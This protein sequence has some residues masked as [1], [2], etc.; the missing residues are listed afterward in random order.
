MY[1]GILVVLLVLL[2]LGET[3]KLAGFVSTLGWGTGVL[4]VMLLAVSVLGI[5]I[6][7]R[8]GPVDISFLADHAKTVLSVGDVNSRT[9]HEADRSE[10]YG[11]VW[12]RVRSSPSNLIVGEGFGQALINFEN[13]EGVP[14][15]QP[16]N[17]SLTVLGRLGLLGLSIWLLFIILTTVRYVQVL[18]MRHASW[19]PRPLMLWL[20]LFFLLAFLLTSV[21]PS[22]EFSHGAIP[23]YFLQGLA[24]GMLQNREDN[25]DVR[26]FAVEG[27]LGAPTAAEHHRP[28]YS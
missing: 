26:L 25:S 7:G 12:D 18:R 24:I 19:G 8:M 13:E 14:V 10:W 5:E 15:R 6:Q 11:Q 28:A 16:H 22:L 1:V 9:S 2:L 4:V 23:F 27:A 20:F 17:S 21:Q 3:K